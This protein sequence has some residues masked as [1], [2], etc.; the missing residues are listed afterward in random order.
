M[1][2]C[3]KCH[4]NTD[5]HES[6][7]AWTCSFKDPRLP[8][9][10]NCRCLIFIRSQAGK[11]FSCDSNDSRNILKQLIITTEETK[12]KLWRGAALQAYSL[13]QIQVLGLNDLSCYVA[14]SVNS[15]YFH[16]FWQIPCFFTGSLWCSQENIENVMRNYFSYC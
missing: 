6:S 15:L 3:H 2:I 4:N 1:V 16:G 10:Y 8:Q 9:L 14:S 5:F 13:L 11:W 12:G 7:L